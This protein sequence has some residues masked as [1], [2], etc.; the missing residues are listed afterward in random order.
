MTS[1]EQRPR[2]LVSGYY[3]FDNLGDEAI[4]EELCNELKELTDPQSIVILSADPQTTSA[5]YG[6]QAIKRTDFVD[7]CKY[8]CGSSL[9]VSGG[10]GLFQNTRSLGSIVFY[11]AQILLARALGVPVMIYAQGIGPLHGKQAEQLTRRFWQMANTITV[12]DDASAALLKSWQLSGTRTAD[13]VWRL[14]AGA[15]SAETRDCLPRTKNIIAVSLR[16]AKDF[17]KAHAVTLADLMAEQLPADAQAL[18]LPL[19][20]SQDLEPLEHFQEAW[21]KRG[22]QATMFD[23]RQLERPSQW[24]SLLQTCRGLVGMRLHA[25]IMALKAGIPVAGIAYDPKVGHVLSEFEQPCLILTKECQAKQWQEA[26]KIFAYATDTEDAAAR[27]RLQVAENLSC[28]NFELLAKILNMQRG[29]R[30][31]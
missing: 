9:F 17:T 25:I 11:G 5:R 1:K 7:L 27:A 26:L 29:D 30:P 16:S 22:R 15:L 31:S 23:S 3:G 20:M 10:G 2:V 8:L 6:V 13:P 12:R 4:L 19:Q 14:K 24:I 18:L 21:Q 28:Q